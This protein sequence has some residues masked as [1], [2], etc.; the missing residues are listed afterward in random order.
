MQ[1]RLASEPFNPWQVL[2]EYETQ[3]D[4]AGSFGATSVFTGTLRTKDVSAMQIEHYPGM[5]EKQLEKICTAAKERWQ[6]LDI[7]LIHRHG[8]IKKHETIVLIAVWSAHRNAA[9]KA[10]REIIDSIK[11]EATFWKQ[12]HMAAGKR[13]VATHSS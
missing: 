1:I 9:F 8:L 10:C 2:A 6:V 12:E 5:T 13:W 7:L 4:Y 11:T 3:Q